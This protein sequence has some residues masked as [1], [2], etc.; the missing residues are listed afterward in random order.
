MTWFPD[1]PE[2]ET[3]GSVSRNVVGAIKMETSTS[4]GP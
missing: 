4:D 2:A 3:A 1:T